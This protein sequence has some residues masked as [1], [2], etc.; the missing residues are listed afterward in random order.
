MSERVVFV[1]DIHL[2]HRVPAR[3]ERFEQFLLE[4]L[5]ELGVSRVF[6]LGD[7]FNIWYRDARLDDL[8]GNRIFSI[9]NRFIDQGGELEFV[10]GNRD[11]ALCFD[12][13]IQ[14]PFPIHFEAIRRTLGRRCFHL[15]HG[16]DLCRRDFGYR[17]LHGL[18]RRPLPMKA[19]HRLS[20]AAKDQLVRKMINLTHEVTRKKSLWK[21]QPYWPYVEKMI[22]EGVD[23]CV[24]GH[25]HYRTYRILEGKRRV[26]RHFILPRWSSK[27]SG[28]IYDSE[29]D[30]FEFFDR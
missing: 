5:R 14:P 22:D 4:D 11:F 20:S 9:L 29:D 28:L 19:F 21:T 25:R 13:V 2:D 24:Q 27:A 26:G 7:V 3:I 16:D 30:S 1:S 10:V 12:P 6:L 15:C 23:V 18:I 8:F 17:L